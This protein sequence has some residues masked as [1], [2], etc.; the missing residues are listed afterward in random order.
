MASCFNYFKTLHSILE[1]GMKTLLPFFLRHTS[2]TCQTETQA[3]SQLRFPVL[4]S[5]APCSSLRSPS[6]ASRPR[7]FLRGE[8]RD[9]PLPPC[10]LP[11]PRAS[12][13]LPLS[14]FSQALLTTCHVPV[15]PVASTSQHRPCVL[16]FF[17]WSPA[18]CWACGKHSLKGALLKRAV[19]CSPFLHSSVRANE[20]V[21]TSQSMSRGR[22]EG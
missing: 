19:I 5:G 16:P 21:F 6:P 4:P 10:G 18:E 22:R 12:H 3:S 14:L 1:D 2:E 15:V 13:C 8:A 11:K 20:E 9:P 17:P 7:S